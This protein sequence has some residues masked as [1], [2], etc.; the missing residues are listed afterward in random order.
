MTARLCRISKNLSQHTVLKFHGIK[1]ESVT[2]IAEGRLS[3]PAAGVGV[4]AVPGILSS[5]PE[6]FSSP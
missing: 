2:E 4:A 1:Y 6:T 5:D 3:V